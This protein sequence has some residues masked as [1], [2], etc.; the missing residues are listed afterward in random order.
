[1][2]VKPFEMAGS[3]VSDAP[4]TLTTTSVGASPELVTVRP[5]STSSAVSERTSA[6]STGV[7]LIATFASFA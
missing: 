1:V 4:M 7:P 5:F 3:V 6:P 2:T